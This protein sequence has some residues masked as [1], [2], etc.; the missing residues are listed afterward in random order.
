MVRWLKE[1]IGMQGKRKKMFSVSRTQGSISL[2]EESTQ[3]TEN[4]FR[5]YQRATDR[6]YPAHNGTPKIGL[7]V[8]VN[9]R[10]Q[11][12]KNE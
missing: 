1:Y 7:W 3:P 6:S 11:N 9:R 4:L 5:L 12:D 2:R 8:T 10:V